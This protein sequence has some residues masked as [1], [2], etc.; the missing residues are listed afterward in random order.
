MAGKN[1]QNS[2]LVRLF[3]GGK[4]TNMRDIASMDEIVRYI[5]LNV[6]FIA[7]ILLL[8]GF[9]ISVLLEGNVV[10]SILDFSVAILGT[11]GLITLRTNTSY[12]VSASIPVCAFGLLCVVLTFS[13]AA[14]GFAGLWI[15]AFPLMSIFLLGLWP[16]I[17]VSLLLLSLVG[18]VVFI[19]GYSGFNYTPDI[20]FRLCGVYF[21]VFTLTIVYEGVRLTKENWIKRLSLD[22]QAERDEIAAMKDNLKVGLFLM[23]RNY[24]IQPQYS[25]ALE[26]VLSETGLQGRNFVDLLSASIKSKEQETL[27]DYF[28]MVFD[29][30]FDIKMLE[31]INPLHE[32]NYIHPGT[33][34]EKTLRCSFAAVDRGQDTVFILGTVQDITNEVELQRQLSEEEGKRQEEMRSIFEIIQVEPRVF[35]DFIED[36]EYE[37][38]RI[39]DTLKDRELSSQEAMVEIYQSVHAIKSNAVILGLEQFSEKLHA[40]ESEIKK[41]REHETIGYEEIL[42]ITLELEKIMREKDKF[43]KTIEK[44][45]SFK[46]GDTRNQ[47]EYVLVQSLIKA[48]EKASRDLDKKVRF[49]V[50][51]IDPQIIENG[52]RRLIKEVLT[53]LVRNAVAHG[54]E[55]PEERLAKGKDECGLIR[56]S[57]KVKDDKIHIR[58]ADDGK[59]LNFNRIREQ[60]RKTN[61]IQTDEEAQDKNR[62][63]QVLFA[64]GFSTAANE[65]VHAGRGIGLNLVRERLQGINGSIKLQTE[66][67]KGTTFNV[68][69]PLNMAA[70]INQAS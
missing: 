67:G 46:T 16:G 54:I 65:G 41:I 11:I 34:E 64:P 66:E 12:M 2:G 52:P 60:A 14:Q 37:F 30:A 43:R 42:H 4:F 33:M 68:F 3:T 58:L 53:Q 22:L 55:S 28:T 6:T 48:S 26:E 38:N 70:E 63:V 49:V 1:S 20:A 51:R 69:I 27:K 31:D 17:F 7:G 8:I 32:F 57:I 18:A 45:Q 19:P 13:G 29:R 44:I 39:N 47:D 50:D 35:G 21:L 23:D 10:R 36:T 15:Y 24:I 59:G 62:L 9:G 56:L 40:L 61:L 25:K 5:M